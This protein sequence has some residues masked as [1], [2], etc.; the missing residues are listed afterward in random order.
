[1]LGLVGSLIAW[2]AYSD[3]YL[4]G[5]DSETKYVGGSVVSLLGCFNLYTKRVVVT[6][7]ND[8]D[9]YHFG[10]HL[11]KEHE[12]FRNVQKNTLTC[13]PL[14]VDI[15]NR[16]QALT[17]Y[18]AD[19]PIHTTEKG[20]IVSFNMT[21]ICNETSP[22]SCQYVIYQFN[23]VEDYL[24]YTS[25]YKNE[26]PERIK[27]SKV[28]AAKSFRT[29]QQVDLKLLEGFN[30]FAV[31]AP[32]EVELVNVIITGYFTSYNI[33]LPLPGQCTIDIST[34][35]CTVPINDH[36]IV[37]TVGHDKVCVLAK[38][39]IDTDDINSYPVTVAPHNSSINDVSLS[40]IAL[41]FIFICLFLVFLC[42]GIKCCY[43]YK[44]SR[45]ADGSNL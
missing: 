24:K 3:I 18:Q 21:T 39:L 15:N 11:M 7:E 32:K 1:M 36:S 35:H 27:K 31:Y 37:P 44:S 6:R 12:L 33:S 43:K 14:Q 22:S 2:L 38:S 16:N 8:G 25:D 45:A 4:F 23:S 9:D 29:S 5:L 19:R 10:L 40:M 13:L 42:I 17:C 20:G 26:F 28:V 34:D 30:Y 41:S